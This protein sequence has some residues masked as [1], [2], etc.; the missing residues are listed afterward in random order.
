[1][2]ALLIGLSPDLRVPPLGS[3]TWWEEI[4][5][6][7]RLCL[8]SSPFY[9]Y[10]LERPNSNQVSRN[11]S[12]SERVLHSQNQQDMYLYTQRFIIVNYKL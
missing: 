11:L 1:M 6:H 3:S 7:W 9:I 4:V 10:Y 5:A 12:Y 8:L 2:H